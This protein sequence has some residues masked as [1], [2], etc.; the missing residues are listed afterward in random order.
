MR[1][2][3]RYDHAPSDLPRGG[4]PQAGPFV[5]LVVMIITS[6]AHFSLLTI[7]LFFPFPILLIIPSF[8][9]CVMFQ[10]GCVR[11]S[12]FNLDFASRT[13]FS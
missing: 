10:L 7:F 8:R 9:L 13:K 2:D 6:K 5:A 12:G 4:T 1:Y 3:L 11:S